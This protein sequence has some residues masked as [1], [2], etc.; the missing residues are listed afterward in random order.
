MD[1]NQSAKIAQEV[2]ELL[3]FASQ[4]EWKKLLWDWF[5]STV[6]GSYDQ[7]SKKEK[8]NMAEVY[9][10]MDDFIQKVGGHIVKSKNNSTNL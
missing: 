2:V 4:E 5:K 7:L 9:E 6:S 1:S 10:K 3:D 8:K